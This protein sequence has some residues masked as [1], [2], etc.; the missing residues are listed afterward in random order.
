MHA[1]RRISLKPN[2]QFLFYF[3]SFF[4]VI[5][6][7]VILLS[8]SSYNLAYS[9]VLNEIR[10][11]KE[12]ALQQTG[13]SLDRVLG[14][15]E[16]L[17]VQLGLDG[18]IYTSSRNVE[19]AFLLNEVRGK[20]SDVA[21]ENGYV[22]SIQVYLLDNGIVLSSNA[23]NRPYSDQP[24]DRWIDEFAESGANHLWLP[25]RSFV[26]QDG[27]D[28]RVVTLVRKLPVAF[29]E[30]TGYIAVHL[31][32]SKLNDWLKSMDADNKGRVILSEPDGGIVSVYP[33]A[34]TRNVEA[35]EVAAWLDARSEGTR[36]GR[37]DGADA[38]IAYGS[39][40]R[41]GW[42][43]VSITDLAYLE[44]KLEYIRRVIVLTG[45]LLV[46]LGAVISYFLSR[47]MY[48]PIR[49][50]FEKT[51]D[52][53]QELELPPA[54]ATGDS[55]VFVSGMVDQF[56]HRHRELMTAYEGSRPAMV[57]RFLYQLFYN[58]VSGVTDVEQRLEDMRLP[59]T[60][61]GFVVMLIEIDD[62]AALGERYSASDLNLFRYATHNIVQELSSGKYACLSTEIADNQIAVLLN[63]ESVAEYDRIQLAGLAG[64]II[65]A[66]RSYLSLSVTAGFGE[67][68]GPLQQ[69][70]VSFQQAADVIRRKMLTDDRKV[71]FHEEE[72][73]LPSFQ[74]FYPSHLEKT[75]MN[76]LRAGNE[77]QAL[78]GLNELKSLLK[79]KPELSHENVSR[80]YNRLIDSIID[81]VV[82]A[83][84]SWETV[85]GSGNVY[86]DLARQETIESIHRWL[87]PLCAGVME[88][89]RTQL[90]APSKVDAAIA[91]M[92]EHY[93]SDISV[94]QIA[95][96]VQLN[97]AYF[98]RLFKQST[99][100]TVLEHLTRIRLDR[101]KELLADPALNLH[102]IAQRI[103]Y[104]NT[105]SYIRFFRKYEGVTPGE[106][107]KLK[108]PSSPLTPT[109][110][111]P[112]R[113]RS[114]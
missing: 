57:D 34:P 76:H 114:I 49:R 16:A 47:T 101:S 99:G 69:A 12:N 33:P 28:Y 26:D 102:E 62:Y 78:D 43:L 95:D 97:P 56:M 48:N 30:A 42:E 72:G 7:P 86:R 58:R 21:R 4:L 54:S 79:S 71:L 89:F 104:N 67:A 46:A 75:L 110:G 52:M 111:D 105:N 36:V 112:A 80:L 9:T 25:T 45:L 2:K 73:H 20:I 93:T 18:G 24:F 87:E 22:Q 19:D 94:E 40:L 3:L 13:A 39:P 63:L 81:L 113:S 38:L 50:L 55:L 1:N 64:E 83:G 96:A 23:P 84:M 27:N 41:N 31:H 65:Q 82:D 51:R 37:V 59:I 10:T 77:S 70:H 60:S 17:S 85:Y 92:Q 98:S 32:E 90:R 29:P 11:G 61:S 107:R 106:Y 15:M 74:Y 108:E 103:G 6:L 53:Q 66:V 35:G 8:L 109:S 44:K 14:D 100:K 88:H 68:V 5:L 91:F